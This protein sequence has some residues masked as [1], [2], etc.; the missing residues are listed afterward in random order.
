MKNVNI[1]DTL[2]KNNIGNEYGGSMFFFFFIYYL[3]YNYYFGNYYFNFD[4]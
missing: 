4:I 3:Y 2:F 1:S